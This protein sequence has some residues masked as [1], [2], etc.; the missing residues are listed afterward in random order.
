MACERKK[1]LTRPATAGESAVAGHPLPTGEGYI[2]DLGTRGVQPKMRDTPSPHGGEGWN[3][4]VYWGC[5]LGLVTAR[6]SASGRRG[7]SELLAARFGRVGVLV[8][9]LSAFR[10]GGN[11]AREAL[12]SEG[13]RSGF[14]PSRE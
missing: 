14:P 5:V 7:R 6:I 13:L 2:S 8:E 4:F 9:E 3:Q 10:E 11:P 12:S 1:P